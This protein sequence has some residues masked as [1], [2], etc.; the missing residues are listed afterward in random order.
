MIE[1]ID[2]GNLEVFGHS[3]NINTKSNKDKEKRKKE[4]KKEKWPS[5][6]QERQDHLKPQ[7]VD[8]NP[9]PTMPQQQ[10]EPQ[11]IIHQ[12]Q[13]QKQRTPNRKKTNDQSSH[14]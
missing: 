9:Q 13:A 3:S 10:Q 14:L 6:S 8:N 2:I 7:E 5:Q 1:H 12:T 4:R 11:R